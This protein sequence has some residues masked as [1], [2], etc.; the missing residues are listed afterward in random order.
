MMRFQTEKEKELLRKMD[1]YDEDSEEYKAIQKKL[2]ELDG[3]EC[4]D[5][6]F[7]H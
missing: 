2:I 4:G 6:P 1:L 5:T 3:K 7:C